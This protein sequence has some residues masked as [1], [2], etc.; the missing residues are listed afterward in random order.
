MYELERVNRFAQVLN[1]LFPGINARTISGENVLG[2]WPVCLQVGSFN[3]SEGVLGLGETQYYIQGGEIHKC[4]LRLQ[5]K[6]GTGIKE[7]EL[8][9]KL[10]TFIAGKDLEHWRRLH[11]FQNGLSE[12]IR[13]VGPS[14]KTE[15]PD[16]YR[17]IF[18]L[19]NHSFLHNGG[20]SEAIFAKNQLYWLDQ[21]VENALNQWLESFKKDASQSLDERQ[22]AINRIM[23]ALGLTESDFTNSTPNSKG[24]PE[25]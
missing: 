25:E 2:D 11:G 1:R 17:R 15:H 20:T 18:Y 4:L 21:K 8:E 24:A 22:E 14:F 9:W 23:V 6:N 7:S 5:M 10:L 19:L 3:G 13:T 16:A 12:A